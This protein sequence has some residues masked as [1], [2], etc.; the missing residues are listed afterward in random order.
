MQRSAGVNQEQAT[1]SMLG[2][3]RARAPADE[4]CKPSVSEVQVLAHAG[5]RDRQVME[6]QSNYEQQTVDSL[7]P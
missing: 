7:G 4:I 2:V 1:E 5:D 6:R 3:V